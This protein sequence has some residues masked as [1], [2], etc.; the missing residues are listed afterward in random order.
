[1]E[2]PQHV[3]FL[4]V[5][6]IVSSAQATAEAGSS[7]MSTNRSN[8][9]LNMAHYSLDDKYE[10]CLASMQSILKSLLLSELNMSRIYK[11]AWE[12]ALF[13][14]QE[15]Q[16]WL[17][18]RNMEELSEVAIW[19]YTLEYPSLYRKFNAAT[20]TAGKGPEEYEAY[21]FKSLHFLLTQATLSFKLKDH[22]CVK[23]YRGTDVMFSINDL[24]RFGQFTSTSENSKVAEAFDTVTFFKLFTC[25]GIDI[26]EMSFMDEEEVLVPP[27]EI[28]KVTA[29]EVTLDGKTVDAKSVG[30]CS[31]HNC[32]F[33]GEGWDNN[34]ACPGHQVLYL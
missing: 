21:P 31:Y 24:F 1:M 5:A 12:E 27:Y 4:L 20:R 17:Y 10:G 6:F 34:H 18:P 32:A 23:V 3:T 14:W 26:S 28:F 7:E 15:N 2:N 22:R 8:P 33:E 9:I 11:E 13:N 30:T 16:S 29:V 25:E 19:A